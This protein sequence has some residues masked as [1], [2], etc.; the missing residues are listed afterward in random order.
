[1]Q[2]THWKHKNIITFWNLIKKINILYYKIISLLDKMKFV[3]P[4]E[5]M[6]GLK[7]AKAS[8]N[9]KQG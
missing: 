9:W 6:N 4:A 5:L 2:G 8:K 1:M 7:N 3:T